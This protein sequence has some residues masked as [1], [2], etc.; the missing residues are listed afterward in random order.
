MLKPSIISYI[1]TEILHFPIEKVLPLHRGGT[2]NNYRI[3]T[4]QG[5][6]VLKVFPLSD[7]TT[8]RA[9]HLLLIDRFLLNIGLKETPHFIT[10][11]FY[12]YENHIFLISYF[13]K[14]EHLSLSKLSYQALLSFEKNEQLLAVQ[15]PFNASFLKPLIKPDD[16]LKEI[17]KSIEK[18]KL[19][20]YS[21]FRFIEPK[22]SFY[23]KEIYSQTPVLSQEPVIIH[24]D[25]KP[26][27][28]ILKN[29]NLIMLDFEMMRLGYTV[30]DLA[31]FALSL[32]LQH[33]VWRYN[34]KLFSFIFKYFTQTFHLKKEDWVYGVNMY[35]L[36]LLNRR[37]YSSK[38]FLSP[39]KSWL[40]LKHLQK[41]DEI[42]SFIESYY[43]GLN[44]K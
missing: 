39:R 26:D 36:R 17:S 40:L 9:E 2:S 23:L 32:V 21:F 37:L 5:S 16:L 38:L 28:F 22:I 8:K 35:F 11:Q 34:K 10:D 41:H 30:E 29:G 3:E 18:L 19:Q 20:K 13:I 4:K 33:S 27:N 25:T 6:F 15:N 42:M 24:A 7:Y 14:G 31:Q 12:I 44:G 43:F 1:E